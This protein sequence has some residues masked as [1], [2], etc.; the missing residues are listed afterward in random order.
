VSK[1]AGLVSNLLSNRN[2]LEREQR[3]LAVK[4]AAYKASPPAA[5]IGAR[6]TL[7]AMA[8]GAGPTPSRFWRL[9]PL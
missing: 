6:G 1:F 4:K 9:P 8:I 3:Y 2:Q 7:G 5:A